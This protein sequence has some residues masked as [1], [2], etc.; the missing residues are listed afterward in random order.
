MYDNLFVERPCSN[1]HVDLTTH[2]YSYAV[3]EQFFCVYI[4]SSKL[5]EGWKNSAEDSYENPR[6]GQGFA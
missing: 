4:A 6:H 3:V 1:C 5:K 2:L